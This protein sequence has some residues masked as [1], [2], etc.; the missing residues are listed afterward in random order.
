MAQ[1]DTLRYRATKFVMRHKAGVAASALIVLSLVGG[2][3]A[4]AWQAHVAREQ[5]SRA[6]RRFNDVRRLATSFLFEFHDAIEPLPGSTRARELVVRRASEYL[7]SLASEAANDP[8][9]TREL[10][11]AYDKVGDVQGL[12]SFANLGDTAGALRSHERSLALRQA[13]VDA[14]PSDDALQSELVETLVHLGSI[15][16]VTRDY[17]RALDYARR[18]LTIR[19]A[20][21][22]RVPDGVV[23]R[24]QLAASY[25]QIGGLL[26]ATGDFNGALENVRREAREF[27]ALLAQDPSSGRAQRNAAIAYRQLGALLEK[28]GDRVV[29]LENYRK[30][31]ALDEGRVRANGNDAR[32]RLDLSYDYASIGYTL[33]TAG[34]IEG[35]L[36]SYRQALAE[37]EWAANADPSDV[38]ARDTVVRAHVSIGQVFRRANRMDEALPH[39][40]KAGEIA[41]A[42]YRSDPANGVAADRVASVYS[43]LANT[44]ASLASASKRPADALPHWR[45]ARSWAR[46]SIEIR[47]AIRARAPVPGAASRDVDELAT[48]IARCDA[49]LSDEGRRAR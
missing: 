20:R 29:A 27:E 35:A 16:D 15:V 48:L 39:L 1:P 10:A 9:L 38:N 6:E 11:A 49:A 18:A 31:A 2:V 33:S 13:L 25:H 22:A 21:L 47:E 40:H 28:H 41:S 5:R 34:D 23:E 43:A 46:K 4:T 17:A 37:R 3:M 30:A 8:S 44:H 45:D 12:P 26:A 24:T 14:R 19:E 7:D 32:A 42:R 36:A